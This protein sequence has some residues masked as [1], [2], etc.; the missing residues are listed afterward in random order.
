MVKFKDDNPELREK[1]A[2][3]ESYSTWCEDA[4]KALPGIARFGVVIDRKI[5]EDGLDAIAVRCW[6]ELQK[7][8]HM[9]FLDFSPCVLMSDWNN[10]GID[11][12]C[13]VDIGNAIAMRGLRL[14]SGN[15][16]ACLDWNNNYGDDPEKEISFHCGPV[17][18]EMMTAKGWIDGHQIIRN[19]T[20]NMSYGCCQGRIK[21]G[22]MVFAS[23]RT[24]DGRLQ[25]Y[26]GTGEFTDD[27]IEKEFF[28]CAAVGKIPKLQKVLKH[29]CEEGHRHHKSATHGDRDTANAFYHG[30]T[31]YRGF[32][33]RRPQLEETREF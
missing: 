3:L 17:A 32:D 31:R 30:L 5:R 26:V 10:R 15:L 33:V 27:P 24:A 1:I 18:A 28:G 23:S 8:G 20:G 2:F 6:D 12:A 9:P 7:H 25:F 21:P 29:V 22:K 14:A 11:S 19:A 4:K 16:S 13:E